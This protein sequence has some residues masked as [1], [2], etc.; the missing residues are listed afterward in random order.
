MSSPPSADPDNGVKT[1]SR[2]TRN[3]DPIDPLP[4]LSPDEFAQI[5][6]EAEL[7]LLN[8]P[9]NARAFRILG[10]LSRTRFGRGANENADASCCSPFASGKR[11]V[12][13]MMRKS[14]Q[15]RDYR[16]AMAYADDASQDP[17]RDCAARSDDPREARGKSGFKR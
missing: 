16:A 6:A 7:A 12:Y 3:S 11:A 1:L 8:D 15:Q 9:L 17:S 4:D 10:R 2:N 13:W 14:Y 5:R